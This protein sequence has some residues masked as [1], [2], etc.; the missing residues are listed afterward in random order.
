VL[1]YFQHVWTVEF[2]LHSKLNTIEEVLVESAFTDS[3]EEYEDS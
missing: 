2:S 1:K 3:R